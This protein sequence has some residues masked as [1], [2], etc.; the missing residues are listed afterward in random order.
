MSDWFLYDNLH[1]DRWF[2]Y[3]ISQFD[4]FLYNFRDFYDSIFDLD[5]GNYFFNDSINGFVLGDDLILDVWSFIVD[6]FFHNHFPYSFNFNDF[7]DFFHNLL[8]FFNKDFNLFGYFH[9]SLYWNNFFFFYYNFMILWLS[10]HNFFCYFVDLFD[11][12]NFFHNSIDIL[13]FWHF[14]NNLD[15]FFN[16]LGHLDYL[17]YYLRSLN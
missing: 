6:R 9:N 12:N 10:Y 11:L 4:D 1:G 14:T 5:N 3:Y 7:R 15:Y 2:S 16:N 8:N 17:L 13:Y